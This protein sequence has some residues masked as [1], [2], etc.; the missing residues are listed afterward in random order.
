MLGRPCGGRTLRA[1]SKPRASGALEHAQLVAYQRPAPIIVRADQSLWP[2]T[3]IHDAEGQ[4]LTPTNPGQAVSHIAVAELP[5]LR[6]VAGRE[7]SRRGFDVSVDGHSVG[8]VKDELSGFSAYVHIADV[9][10]TAGVHTFVLTYPHADLTPGS[11]ENQLTSLNAIALVPH[12]PPSELIEVAPRQAA[13]LCGRPLDW[14]E[15][16]I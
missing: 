3:W 12:S 8:R 5:E 15:L 6:T 16:V 10:L 9:F 1:D 14:I 4:L 13:Q 2:A 7:H 11:G